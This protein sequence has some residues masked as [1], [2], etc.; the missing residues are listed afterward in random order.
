MAPPGQPLISLRT[1]TR[2][3]PVQSPCSHPFRCNDA[4]VFLGALVV[5]H[6]ADPSVVPVGSLDVFADEPVRAGF[7]H[8]VIAVSTSSPQGRSLMRHVLFSLA[9]ERSEPGLL[10]DRSRVAAPV[11]DVTIVI[12]VKRMAYSFILLIVYARYLYTS[13]MPLGKVSWEKLWSVF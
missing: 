3:H 12:A 10:S 9:W 2:T 6:R 13:I 7:L 8:L 4:D 1:Q 5:E 11:M